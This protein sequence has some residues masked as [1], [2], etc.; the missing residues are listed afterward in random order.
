MS[1]HHPL[2]ICLFVYKD[3][4]KG[5]F[6]MTNTQAAAEPESGYI[7][8]PLC[9]WQADN[10]SIFSFYRVAFAASS[11]QKKTEATDPIPVFCL[12]QTPMSEDLSLKDPTVKLVLQSS[13]SKCML[14][15]ED[16][17]ASWLSN[18]NRSFANYTKL[19]SKLLALTNGK[20]ESLVHEARHQV[21]AGLIAK[22]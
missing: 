4:L 21:I 9:E 7:L 5:G 17:E 2:Q 22:N 19:V 1:A 13:M 12:A 16:Q 15:P 10:D 18:E 11:I 8:L 6:C 20:A 3:D 14:T